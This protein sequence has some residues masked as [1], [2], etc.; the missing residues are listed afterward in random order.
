MSYRRARFSK[1]VCWWIAI[2][3]CAATHGAI[4][5][6]FAVVLGLLP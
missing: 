1:R 2:A 5:L 3:I 6:L 4:A